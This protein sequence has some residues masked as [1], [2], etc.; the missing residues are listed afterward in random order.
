MKPAANVI[1]AA[2][3]ARVNLPSPWRLAMMCSHA[4]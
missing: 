2:V 1:G 4:V 3:S